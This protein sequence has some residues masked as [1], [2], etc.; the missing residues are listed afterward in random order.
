MIYI[1]IYIYVNA[2][3]II[4]FVLNYKKSVYISRVLLWTGEQDK[5]KHT[6]V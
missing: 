1:Y 2:V 3:E 6:I 4:S 5:Y